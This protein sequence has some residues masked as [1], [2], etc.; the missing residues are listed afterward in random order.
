M[1]YVSDKFFLSELLWMFTWKYQ[2]NYITF[3]I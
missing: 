3:L 2:L 1:Y